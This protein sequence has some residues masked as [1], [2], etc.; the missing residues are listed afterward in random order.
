M[1]NHTAD[2]YDRLAE[3]YAARFVHELDHKPLDRALLNAFA[4]QLQGRGIVADIGCGPGHLARYLHGRG[5]QTVGIDLSPGMIAMARRL[6]PGL[7]YEVGNMLALDLE[8]GAW[9]G[10]AAFYSI[11]HVPPADV[12]RALAEFRRVLQPGGL[13]LISFHVGD[14]RVHRN[15]MLGVPVSLDFQF[16]QMLEMETM[17]QQAAFMV[18]ARIEREPYT[19]VEHPSRR[20]YLLARKSNDPVATR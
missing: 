17:L 13:A 16:I 11:I 20:G 7:T 1:D 14:E 2:S 19:A 4:E 10:I 3:E 9:A 15:E 12:P 6:N 5:L 18:E 8:D